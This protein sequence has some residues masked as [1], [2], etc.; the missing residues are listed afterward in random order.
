MM[1]GKG[2]WI[3]VGV[4]VLLVV[5]LMLRGGGSSTP[6]ATVTPIGPTAAQ[7]S[8]ETARLQAATSAFSSYENAGVAA[9]QSNN[10]VTI[11]N[12]DVQG[13]ETITGEQVSGS[14]QL[15]QEEGQVYESLANTQAS[16]NLA[17]AKV[18]AKTSTNQS[19]LGLIGSLFTDVTKIATG[20]GGGG[21]TPN[22][23]AGL[24]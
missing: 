4:V 15:A 21:G 11:N 2:V 3:A 12:Q 9:L 17:L 13:A 1:E 7:A 18:K 5:V 19:L 14:E 22:P 16:S 6:A 23:A 24:F 20:G 8:I 10:A